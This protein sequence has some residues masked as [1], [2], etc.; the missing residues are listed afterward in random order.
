M[1]G[2]QQHEEDGAETTAGK[3]SKSTMTPHFHSLPHLEGGTRGEDERKG[4]VEDE[5]F[6]S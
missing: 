2:L 4:D 6:W 5:T 3:E 1:L